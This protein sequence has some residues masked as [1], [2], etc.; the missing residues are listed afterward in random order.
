ML[1]K[2]V[3]VGDALLLGY[4]LGRVDTL[5]R[6]DGSLLGDKVGTPLGEVDG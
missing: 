1:G 4:A 6:A 5:G 3:M 2:S